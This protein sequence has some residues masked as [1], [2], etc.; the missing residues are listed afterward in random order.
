MIHKIFVKILEN[1]VSYRIIFMLK[2]SSRQ[3]DGVR[4]EKDTTN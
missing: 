2:L 4:R 3:I 1:S